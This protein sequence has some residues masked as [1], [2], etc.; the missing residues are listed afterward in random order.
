MGITDCFFIPLVFLFRIALTIFTRLPLLVACYDYLFKDCTLF[1]HLIQFAMILLQYILL[2]SLQQLHII[3][4][5]MISCYNFTWTVVSFWPVFYYRIITDP[6]GRSLK[7]MLSNPKHSPANKKK[8]KHHQHKLKFYNANKCIFTSPQS[9]GA[10]AHV[11]EKPCQTV[12][13]AVLQDLQTMRIFIDDPLR[14]TVPYEYIAKRQIKPPDGS[15]YD[16]IAFVALVLTFMWPILRGYAKLL[17][18][19]WRRRLLSMLRRVRL[20]FRSTKVVDNH[21]TRHAYT[22][23]RR[24]HAA[25]LADNDDDAYLASW[26]SDGIF[27]CVDNSATCIIC[28]DKSMF[29]GDLHPGKSTVLTSNGENAPAL[30]GTIRLVLTDDEGANHQYDI[31]DCLYDPESPFNLLGISALSKYFGDVDTKGT[32][33]NSA[34]FESEFTWDH[35]KHTRTF[36]HGVDCLPTLQVN[37]GDSYFKSFCTRVRKFYD[38]A[39]KFNFRVSKKVQFDLQTDHPRPRKKRKYQDTDFEPGME[40]IYKDGAGMNLPVV[41]E[42]A[43]SNGLI[44]RIRFDDG[45]TESVDA[46]HLQLLHQPDLTNIPSTPMDYQREV[47]ED[48]IS[49]ADAIRLA[50][51][52]TLS[53]VQQMLM[54]W[55]HRLYHLPF[56]FMFMLASKGFLPKC[57]LQCK[58]NVPLCV[59]CQFGT[60][61]RRP[62]R[63]KGKKHGSIR[64]KTETRPGDGQSLD[65]IVSAQPGLIPQMS[66]FLTSQRLWGATVVVDHVTDY[67]YCHLM[68]DFTLEET[69]NAKKSWERILFHAGYQAKH[70]HADNGR[71]ADDDFRAHCAERNQSL[72]FCGVGA[73]HQNGIVE[74]KIKILTQ[75]ARTILLHGQRMWPDMINSMFWPFALK[76]MAERLNRLQISPDG[77]TPE[78]KFYGLDPDEIP[79]GTYHTLFCPVYVLD[80]KL[81]SGGIGPPKWEPRSRIGIYLGHSPCHAGSV[82]LVFNPTTGHVSP[83]YHVVFDDDFSTVPYM[84]RGEIPPNWDELYNDNRELATDE[85]YDLAQ[86]WFRSQADDSED[87]SAADAD[88]FAVTSRAGPNIERRVES[89]TSDAVSVVG[90]SLASDYEGETGMQHRDSSNIPGITAAISLEDNSMNNQAHA[91]SDKGDKSQLYMPTCINLHEI[92]LR[93]S[94]RIKNQLKNAENG[95]KNKAHKAFGAVSKRLV[96]LGGLFALLT[97]A[98]EMPSHPLPKNASMMQKAVCKFHECNELYD[99]TLNQLHNFA[100]TADVASNE[101]FTYNQAMRQEDRGEFIKAMMKE[102]EDHESRDHWALVLRSTIPKGIKTIQAIWS[103]KRKRFPDGTLNKHKAR[104]CAHG[105]MQQ[106]GENYWETYSPVVNMLSVRL[107]LVI[108]HIHGLDSKSIDFV[109]A[110]PQAELDVDIWM[111]LPRGMVPDHD[112][113]SKHQY[114]LKLKKNLYGLK[115]ASYNW[116]DK[117][118]SGLMDRGFSPSKIDPCVYLKPGMIVLS[119]V[120]DCIIIGKDM[121]EIDSFVKSMQ[122]G[123]ENFILTDEGDIDKFLGIEIKQLDNNRFEMAQPFLIERICK[124]LGLMDND[125]DVAAN[126]KRSPVGK[127]LLNKDLD[128]KPRKLK[129]KY[130]TAV[131]MLSYLQANT[132]PEISMATHQTAR[133]CND[134]KLSHEQA[135]MRIGRYLLGTRDRGIVYEPDRSKGLEC[136]VDA[137]FAGGWSLENSHDPDNVLSRMGYVIYYAGC[138]VYWVSRLS[139]EIALS[140]AES[141]YMALSMALRE[142]IPLMTLMEEINEVFTLFIDKP[143]FFCKV[144]EDNQSCIKMAVAPKFTPRTKHIAL[145]YHHFKS[146]V[147][148]KIRISYISTDMQKADIFTKPLPDELFFKL[149]FMLMGW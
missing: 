132:R 50:R 98:F 124:L 123:P 146:F 80:S 58:D 64:K 15:L 34:C 136:Y 44:H 20:F 62:W 37:I 3:L 55:H 67:I 46:S 84:N 79:V 9:Q 14:I 117:L 149:R 138:P 53:P 40:L 129:W 88:P 135:I 60:A 36:A 23:V 85:D 21:M 114:V 119:Y 96:R 112:E 26:D 48:F 131:G 95:S 31:P 72:S 140:T 24:R 4:Q 99:G 115:Q 113:E 6:K 142:V 90:N 29:V 75:G 86:S 65:Q 100:F 87:V 143:N 105:G 130:R 94:E 148:T 66:G 120:D 39:V 54:N 16:L 89:R 118:K 28:N 92:G 10:F 25:C 122:N 110:F 68:K 116:F 30:E 73:H 69:L 107:I 82:A 61:R 22:S 97:T 111:E 59:A 32:R 35:G 126:T 43:E 78:S 91:D 147:G 18:L 76:A 49:R 47:S 104:L 103:F 52:R 41:Y 145:K 27:F 38:D 109:L 57:L 1:F 141:E 93:R 128:G 139:G 19:I 71:F 42:G 56:R 144:F 8:L 101:V 17:Y 77:A 70:Y 2:N 121:K 11:D 81:Q 51:P 127:P 83:Q 108:A 74:G 45:H 137:D 13:D 7:E 102:V 5:L 106:W 133:F 63:A 125:W 134:P 33:I 12:M